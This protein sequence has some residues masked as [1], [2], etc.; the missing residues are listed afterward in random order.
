MGKSLN[1]SASAP[2]GKES[3]TIEVS[4]G[5]LTKAEKKQLLVEEYHSHDN[6]RKQIDLLQGY[7]RPFAP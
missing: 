1:F 4:K 5:E 2:G 7:N 6:Q 3:K